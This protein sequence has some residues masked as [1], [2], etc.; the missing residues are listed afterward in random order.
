M[1][2]GMDPGYKNMF[3]DGQI[4]IAESSDYRPRMSVEPGFSDRS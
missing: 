3:E 4:A 2:K 1:F